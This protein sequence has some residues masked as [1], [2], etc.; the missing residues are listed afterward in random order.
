MS[1]TYVIQTGDILLCDINTTQSGYGVGSTLTIPTWNQGIGGLVFNFHPGEEITRQLDKNVWV[2]QKP[3]T[4]VGYEIG[5][6]ERII[7]IT[8]T[9]KYPISTYTSNPGGTGHGSTFR[10][11]F[12]LNALCNGQY[13]TVVNAT[14]TASYGVVLLYYYGDQVN[15]YLNPVIVKSMYYDQVPGKGNMF[16]VRVSLS[17][18]V[19][20]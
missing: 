9:I 17:E 8:T 16:D 14:S 13:N 3:G 15:P 10:S 1:T 4:P 6:G 2:I 11:L 12:D 5:L 19:H 7:N 18:V 20:P